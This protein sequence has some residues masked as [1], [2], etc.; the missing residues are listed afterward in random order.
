M[1][2][3][4]Q[5]NEVTNTELGIGLLFSL[6][7]SNHPRTRGQTREHEIKGEKERKRERE[8]K[9]KSPGLT[10]TQGIAQKKTSGS[11]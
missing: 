9:E 11:K 8:K 3:G 5:T 7:F 2:K 4:E 1:S 6:F 10:R